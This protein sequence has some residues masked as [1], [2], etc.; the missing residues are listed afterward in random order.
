MDFPNEPGLSHLI[1]KVQRNHRTCF[2]A[3][4]LC[5]LS[6]SY[7]A[8]H[9]R[10]EQIKAAQGWR[11]P[12]DP[13]CSRDNCTAQGK[14]AGTEPR[15]QSHHHHSHLPLTSSTFPDWSPRHWF[16][17]S[18]TPTDVQN[19]LPLPPTTPVLSTAMQHVV[20]KAP[21]RF[22]MQSSVSWMLLSLVLHLKDH[23]TGLTLIKVCTAFYPILSDTCNKGLATSYP[24]DGLLTESISTGRSS[25]LH[26]FVHAV[27][28]VPTNLKIRG[29]RFHTFACIIKAQKQGS[30]STCIWVGTAGGTDVLCFFILNLDAEAD[31][32]TPEGP[33]PAPLQAEG[34]ENIV[35]KALY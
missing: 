28:F 12:R 10:K 6:H 30:N 20:K 17:G 15:S 32:T 13:W 21:T 19:A 4:S 33:S 11:Y 5:L 2:T 9:G 16:Q 8:W 18:E 25:F 22:R 1:W 35:G 14:G 31:S 26:Q 27:T 24:A 34:L 23:H 7:L 29:F 3:H